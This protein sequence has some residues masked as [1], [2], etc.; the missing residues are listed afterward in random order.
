MEIFD[1]VK[2]YIKK[3]PQKAAVTGVASFLGLYLL[4]KAFSGS[5][6][7]QGRIKD[8]SDGYPYV[9]SKPV[10]SDE[11]VNHRGKFISQVKYFID[12]NLRK[13]IPVFETLTIGQ[14][15]E[16]RVKIEFYLKEVSDGLFVDY[17]GTQYYHLT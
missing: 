16:G 6:K 13:G 2:T 17:Y 12:L 5:S 15:Y 9:L 1:T 14:N 11:E 7:S 10:L 3:D 8:V 4:S